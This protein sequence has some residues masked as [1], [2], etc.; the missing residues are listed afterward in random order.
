MNEAGEIGGNAVCGPELKTGRNIEDA[1]VET[2]MS[3]R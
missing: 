3:I 1:F 2:M